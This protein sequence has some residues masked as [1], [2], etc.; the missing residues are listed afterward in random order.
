[1]GATSLATQWRIFFSFLR[2]A[3]QIHRSDDVMQKVRLT[4]AVACLSLKGGMFS[5]NCLGDIYMPTY[6][7]YIP[8]TLFVLA[9][10]IMDCMT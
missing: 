6:L 7:S 1:M 4:A 3:K 5:Q 8:L 10:D 9:D 2:Q